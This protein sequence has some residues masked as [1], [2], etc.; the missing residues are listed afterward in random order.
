[1]SGEVSTAKPAWR[2]VRGSRRT[3][4][5]A[6]GLHD[7]VG[8]AARIVHRAALA[9]GDQGPRDVVGLVCRAACP[10]PRHRRGSRA[11]PAPPPRG[12]SPPPTAYR[13]RRRA[14]RNRDGNRRAA[15]GTDRPWPPGRAPRA[16]AR[17]EA[18]G[19]PRQQHAI[20]A[21][22]LQLALQFAGDRHHHDLLLGAADAQRA[23]IPAAM[24]GVEEDQLGLGR[25]RRLGDGL[26]GRL[27]GPGRRARQGQRRSGRPARQ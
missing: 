26:L 25:R 23:G 6:E 4:L 20:A 14:R 2:W 17:H 22:G 13:P 19:R 15:T 27:I 24:A 8:Q 12:R 10:R 21:A 5:L 9:H 16:R 1:M 7:G 3:P 11:P 18:V